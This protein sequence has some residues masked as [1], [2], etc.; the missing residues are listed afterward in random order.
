MLSQQGNVRF[1]GT[2]NQPIALSKNE[3]AAIIGHPRNG[4]IRRGHGSTAV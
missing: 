4:T 2:T 3:A 1:A